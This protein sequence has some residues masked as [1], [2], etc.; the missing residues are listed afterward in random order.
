M[1]RY[2]HG[3]TLTEVLIALVVLSVGLMG[4][5]KLMVNTI[6]INNLNRQRTIATALVQDQ[7]ERLQKAGYAALVVGTTTADYGTI[8]Q[9]PQY[10]QITTV[11]NNAAPATNLRTVTIEMRWKGDTHRMAS[12]TIVGK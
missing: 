12:T 10:K 4:I 8:P 6:T 5:S 9:Q 2:D 11:V 3:F 1:Q 7:M